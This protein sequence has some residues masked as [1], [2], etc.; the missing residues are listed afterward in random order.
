M[1]SFGQLMYCGCETTSAMRGRF[2]S[3][4]FH[5]PAS[6]TAR[7]TALTVFGFFAANSSVKA[8]TFSGWS[9]HICWVVMAVK[10]MPS[11][12]ARAFHGSPTQ[13]PSILPTFM[14]ATICGGGIVISDTSR[15]GLM[16]PA[17]SQ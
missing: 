9:F 8:R 5:W 7:T 12:M 3:L 6:T 16:P 14:L 13:K 4:S 10:P 1:I 17:P 2:S 15:S 11:A